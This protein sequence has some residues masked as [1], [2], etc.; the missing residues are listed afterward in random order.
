M[1]FDFLTKPSQE[2]VQNVVTDFGVDSYKVDVQPSEIEG[3]VLL[4]VE[5]LNHVYADGTHAG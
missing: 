4:K 3:E 5:N 2:S 1:P